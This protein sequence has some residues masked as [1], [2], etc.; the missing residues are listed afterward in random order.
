MHVNQPLEYYTSTTIDKEVPNNVKDDNI[1]T[2]NSYCKGKHEPI[3]KLVKEGDAIEIFNTFEYKG[4][5]LISFRL[6]GKELTAKSTRFLDDIIKDKE[7]VFKVIVGV[8]KM[9]PI[10]RRHCYY[11]IS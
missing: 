10:S 8:P 6:D 3:D 2:H 5:Y 9:H 7:S 11:F 1:L 4:S